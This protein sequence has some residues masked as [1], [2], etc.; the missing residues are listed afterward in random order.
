M[1]LSIK[2]KHVHVSCFW[3]KPNDK[4]YSNRL[5]RCN[6]SASM[7]LNFKVVLCT[8][9]EKVTVLCEMEESVENLDVSMKKSKM[10]LKGKGNSLI[11]SLHNCPKNTP[12]KAIIAYDAFILP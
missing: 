3:V 4:C 10:V 6:N 2:I 7:F 9:W 12:S 5:H 8:I 11:F 1:A